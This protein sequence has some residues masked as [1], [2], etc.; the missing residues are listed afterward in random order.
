MW[1]AIS[2]RTHRWRHSAEKAQRGITFEYIWDVCDVGNY[3]DSNSELRLP[4]GS[5][6]VSSVYVTAHLTSP[7]LID[8]HIGSATRSS[9]ESKPQGHGKSAAVRVCRCRR[10]VVLW[11]A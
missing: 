5:G 11:G 2:L 6:G 4:R 7:M 10:G 3:T 9:T 1:G 8:T